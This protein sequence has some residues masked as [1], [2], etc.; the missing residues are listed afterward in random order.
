MEQRSLSR[1]AADR[2]PS[3]RAGMACEGIRSWLNR[4]PERR[5]R[6]SLVVAVVLAAVTAP[7]WAMWGVSGLRQARVHVRCWGGYHSVLG[8]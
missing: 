2:P 7:A 3:W 5:L 8:G 4:M 6:R 1:L